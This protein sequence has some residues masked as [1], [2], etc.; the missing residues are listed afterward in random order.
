MGHLPH[1]KVWFAKY[2]IEHNGT[3]TA[4]ARDK[5]YK[6]SRRVLDIPIRQTVKKRKFKIKIFNKVKE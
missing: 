2:Y 1:K 3:L 4:S 6:V 5:T